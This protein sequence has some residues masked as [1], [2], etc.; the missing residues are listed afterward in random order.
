VRRIADFQIKDA[1]DGGR[2]DQHGNQGTDKIS[3]VEQVSRHS[4]SIGNSGRLI[5]QRN[6]RFAFLFCYTITSARS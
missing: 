2:R 3:F 4:V 1:S 6:T 5:F